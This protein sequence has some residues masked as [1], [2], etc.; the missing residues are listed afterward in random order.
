MLL[1][2]LIH[3]LRY[4]LRQEE[5][6][7]RMIQVLTLKCRCNL[8]KPII[9]I[10][11]CRTDDLVR[12][13]IYLRKKVMLVFHRLGKGRILGMGVQRKIQFVKIVSM[14]MVD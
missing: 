11:D 9:G 4:F 3:G 7:H 5:S 6:N 1:L 2:P 10:Q 13:R 14:I 8:V 12:H